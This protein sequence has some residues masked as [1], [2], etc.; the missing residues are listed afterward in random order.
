[1]PATPATLLDTIL[2]RDRLRVGLREGRQPI[3]F[4]GL[5]FRSLFPFLY[6]SRQ[7]LDF[8]GC[9]SPNSNKPRLIVKASKFPQISNKLLAFLVSHY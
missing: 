9:L 5:D 7:P 3:D 4:V 2:P 8:V 1:M 6:L